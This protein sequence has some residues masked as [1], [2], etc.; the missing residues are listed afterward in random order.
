M[1][2]VEQLPSKAPFAKRFEE[3][4]GQACEAA[5][6][7]QVARQFGMAQSTVRGID[8]SYLERWEAARKKAPLRQMGVDEIYLGKKQKFVTVVSNLE[9][10]S[11][12][13]WS[14]NVRRKRWTGSSNEI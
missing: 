1:E 2:R 8:L 5:A 14:R 6:A 7:R 11:R 4:V 3:A 9:T 12:Y 13:S 10:A